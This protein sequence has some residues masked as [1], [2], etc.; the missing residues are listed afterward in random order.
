MNL[1][2][3]A[4]SQDVVRTAEQPDARRTVAPAVDIFENKDEFL[5]VADL[6][7]VTSDALEMHFDRNE[8]RFEARRK[9]PEAAASLADQFQPADYRR[10]FALPHGIDAGRI[11]AQ[12]SDGVLH[13]R[14]PKSESLKP[15]QIA[16]KAG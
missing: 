16:V 11:E 2:H 14:L 6:P 12:L 13:V 4:K 1:T 3:S 5:L 10:T 8:L 7:G 15:R 9:A